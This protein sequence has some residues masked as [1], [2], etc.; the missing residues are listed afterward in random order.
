MHRRAT[1]VLRAE[2]RTQR[3]ACMRVICVVLCARGYFARAGLKKDD[4]KAVAW[5]QRASAAGHAS[6]H[7][8]L[9]E[10]CALRTG[11][12]ICAQIHRDWLSWA[13]P[14]FIRLGQVLR[15]SGCVHGRSAGSSAAATCSAVWPCSCHVSA[16]HD[17]SCRDPCSPPP[18]PPPCHDL[19]H[20]SSM[21]A[22]QAHTHTH[23][24]TSCTRSHA[25][26]R[27]AQRTKCRRSMSALHSA[28]VLGGT[29]F[30]LPRHR[31]CGIPHITPC[32]RQTIEAQQRACHTRHGARAVDHRACGS[33]QGHA[34]AMSELGK[35]MQRGDSPPA[36]EEGRRWLESAHARG[37]ATAA[38]RLAK[39]SAGE[40]PAVALALWRVSAEV[41]LVESSLA[42]ATM[43]EAVGCPGPRALTILGVKGF[44]GRHACAR[45]TDYGTRSTCP[46]VPRST[47][48]NR[49]LG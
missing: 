21:H 33:A 7:F 5:L 15:W 27:T 41:R 47:P 25:R 13:W 1:C 38:L 43:R 17:A 4:A 35:L 31:Y 22:C 10:R 8:E 12:G 42:G 6:A 23:T 11:C 20:E 3:F 44:S 40:K 32:A 45:L 37:S 30:K 18:P 16:S 9:A 2:T 46:R 48:A 14:W 26:L 24:P 28:A 29:G 19:H 39:L 49:A 36:R 34:E